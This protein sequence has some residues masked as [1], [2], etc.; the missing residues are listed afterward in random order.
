MTTPDTADAVLVDMK[1]ACRLLS[2]S[3][4][5]LR[6]EMH[7]GRINAQRIGRSIVFRPEELKRYAAD[8]PAW[9][10]SK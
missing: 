8:L 5:K 3:E 6:E 4:V 7:A 10:P 9:E 1:T 2:I